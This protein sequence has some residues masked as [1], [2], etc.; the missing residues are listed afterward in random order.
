MKM[1]VFLV[2]NVSGLLSA[3]PR[4]FYEG[5]LSSPRSRVIDT[6]DM[7]KPLHDY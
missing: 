5:I 7:P 2:I 4:D 6:L 3:I 1:S